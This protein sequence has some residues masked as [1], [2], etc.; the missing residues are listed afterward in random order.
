[1]QNNQCHEAVARTLK[2]IAGKWKPLIL[3][4]LLNDKLRFNE[5]QKAIPGVSQKMLTA[6]LRELEKDRIIHRQVYR[7]V[8]PRVEYWMTDYGRTLRPLLVAMGRWGEKHGR[9]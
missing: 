9:L 7:E 4:H 3:W 6:Q 5:L 2:V 8:P 1:M